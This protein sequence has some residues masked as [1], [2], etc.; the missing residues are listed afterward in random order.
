MPTFLKFQIVLTL[1]L[2]V[3]VYRHQIADAL[4]QRW[5]DVRYYFRQL[6]YRFLP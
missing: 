5:F 3:L 4:R 1:I 6:L 2:A